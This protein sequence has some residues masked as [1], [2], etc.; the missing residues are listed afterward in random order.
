MFES[1]WNGPVLLYCQK[2]KVSQ[3]AGSVPGELLGEE[4]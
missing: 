4:G 3:L 2:L 1:P